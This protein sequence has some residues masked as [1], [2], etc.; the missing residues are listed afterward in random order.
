MSVPPS[1]IT[2]VVQKI[3]LN[4][5]ALKLIG[6][7][8]F[9][10]W[11]FKETVGRKSCISIITVTILKMLGLDQMKHINIDLNKLTSFLGEIYHGY[12][13][14]VQYHNDIHGADVL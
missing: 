14:D 3:E 4:Q 9:D 2:E 1:D 11:R 13:R 12:Q 5:E 10:I 6:S 8:E 7:S